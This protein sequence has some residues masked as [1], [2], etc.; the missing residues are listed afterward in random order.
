[1]T[2]PK[3][4]TNTVPSLYILQQKGAS[5]RECFMFMSHWPDEVFWRPVRAVPCC[6][7]VRARVTSKVLCPWREIVW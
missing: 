1:M 5:P 4:V 2:R 3:D 6:V 7:C